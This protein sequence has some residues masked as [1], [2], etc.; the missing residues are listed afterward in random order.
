MEIIDIVNNIAKVSGMS[1][2]TYLVLVKFIDYKGNSPTKMSMVIVASILEAILY[3]IFVQY[4]QGILSIVT[5]YI[6]HSLVICKILKRKIVY[7]ITITCI[8]FTIVYLLYIISILLSGFILKI[9]FQQINHNNILILI[10]AYIIEN[11]ILYYFFS[12]KRFKNGI[13]FL[14]NEDKVSNI[15]LSV[16]FIGIAIVVF[17]LLNDYRGYKFNTYLLLCIV[18]ETICIIIWIRRKIT[19]YYKQKLK[20]RTIEDLKKEI[21]QKEEQINKILEENRTIATINHKY[22]NRIQALEQISAQILSKPEFIEKIKTEFGT[23][24]GD[25]QNQIN[26]ISKEFSTE[27]KET[28]KQDKQLIKTGIFG[29]DNIL[30]YMREEA[31]KN[32]I[33]FD[34]KTNANINYMVENIIDQ[35]KLETLLADHIKDAIIA[36]NSSN[37]KH[38][39]ILTTISI[40]KNYYEICIYDTGIEFEIKTLLNLGI[41]PVTTHKETGGSGIGFITTFKTLKET[42]ASLIIEEKHPMNNTDYTKVV[43]IRFDGKNEYNICSYRAEKIIAQNKNNGNIINNINV[44]KTPK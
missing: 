5:I 18:I 14:K 25:I 42:N 21:E 22:S 26:K 10:L 27:I 12:K 37:N 38:K 15:G 1:F 28:I 13:P 41:K 20:E 31:E 6:L 17:I 16:I 39:S 35:S 34:F 7:S 43:R 33:K 19:K 2:L 44:I 24:F 23:D 36:I 3:M 30:E 4:L 8:S 29:I 11:V 9:I 32:N 40:I